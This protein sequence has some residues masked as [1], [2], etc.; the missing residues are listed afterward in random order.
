M[1]DSSIQ[2]Q[3]I[4]DYGS[5]DVLYGRGGLATHHEGNKKFRLIVEGKKKEYSQIQFLQKKR[6]CNGF[7]EG[8]EK[9]S[10]GR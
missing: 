9:P 7:S 6:I 4:T 1:S 8:M 10:T 5:N 2:L 3:N